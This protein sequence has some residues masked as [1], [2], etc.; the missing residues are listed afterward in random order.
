MVYV[1]TFDSTV[2]PGT[3]TATVLAVRT[4]AVKRPMAGSVP[5]AAG[6]GEPYRGCVYDG[7]SDPLEPS[8]R[9]IPF[10]ALLVSLA[11]ASPAS[12]QVHKCLDAT[13]KTIYADAPCAP[14]QAGGLL[15]RQRTQRE[16]HQ[17]RIQAA[18]AEK[19][20]H[21]QR[22]QENQSAWAEQAQRAAQLRAAPTVRHSG[23][24]W[25]ARNDLRNAQV[26]ATS[27]MN[28]GGQWDRAAEER[29]K[30]ARNLAR[31]RE[32]VHIS[33]HPI[34]VDAPLKLQHPKFRNCTEFS[35]SDEMGTQ[36][37]RTP[38]LPNQMTGPNG[39]VCHKN[40]PN[41]TCN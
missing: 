3:S 10:A 39:T 23:N 24:D 18:Q 28:N 26:S 34:S 8:M 7:G 12:A 4:M 27:I 15:E 14:G 29:R 6:L 21:A 41:W 32:P 31:D 16:I 1:C 19:R 9:W 35:C 13:G 2:T 20:K 25:E 37:S 38:L 22:M 11:I 33:P 30:H 17:E 5:G 36:Y 40:G